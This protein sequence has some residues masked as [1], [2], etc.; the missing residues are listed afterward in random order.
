MH[1]KNSD[2]NVN[3]IAGLR[4]IVRRFY[5]KLLWGYLYDLRQLEPIVKCLLS[6]FSV[7]FLIKSSLAHL[8]SRAVC[9]RDTGFADYKFAPNGQ[10]HFA[11]LEQVSHPVRVFTLMTQVDLSIRERKPQFNGVVFTRFPPFCREIYEFFVFESL[12]DYQ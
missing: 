10:L 6:C 4:A 3:D 9:R 8:P 11:I 2:G 1:K 7:V 12:R 5:M